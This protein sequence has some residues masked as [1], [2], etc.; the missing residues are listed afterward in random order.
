MTKKP[1]ILSL[2]L[3]EEILEDAEELI[4]PVQSDPRYSI[5]RITRSAVLKLAIVVGLSVLRGE[6]GE[7]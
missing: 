1:V 6:Y 7:N 5:T 2:R 4:A 3:S